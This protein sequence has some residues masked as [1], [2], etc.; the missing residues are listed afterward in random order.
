MTPEA[1]RGIG[2]SRLIHGNVPL[3]FRAQKQVAPVHA[4]ACA[5][6]VFH[7]A[8]AAIAPRLTLLVQD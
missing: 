2:G 8:M 1:E 7:L 3:S 6:R 5:L 4:F